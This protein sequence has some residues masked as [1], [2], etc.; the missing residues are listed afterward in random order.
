MGSWISLIVEAK[1]E[2]LKEVL[3]EL[4]VSIA[5]TYIGDIYTTIICNPD[6]MGYAEPVE[7]YNKVKDYVKDV[8]WID[9]ACAVNVYGKNNQIK[10]WSCKKESEEGK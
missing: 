5:T 3:H 2:N 4:P 8:H 10:A 7:F 1:T 9:N 6:Y